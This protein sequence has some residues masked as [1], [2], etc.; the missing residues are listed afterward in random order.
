MQ[1][2]PFYANSRRTL[3][4]GVLPQGV[5][6]KKRPTLGSRE[7]GEPSRLVVAGDPLS[8]IRVLQKRDDLHLVMKAGKAFTNK[9]S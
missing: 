5:Y 4:T 6:R 8:D 1:F 3:H 9:L 2:R 7:A